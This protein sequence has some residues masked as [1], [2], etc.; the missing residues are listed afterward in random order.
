MK[1]LI[2]TPCEKVIQDVQSGNSLI[3]VF[4][5][6]KIKLPPVDAGLPSDAVA[7]KDWAIFSKWGLLPEEEGR[8]YTSF[9]EVFWPDGRLLASQR[10]EAAQPTKHG[11][12]FIT[13]LRGFPVG[14]NGNIKV[15]CSLES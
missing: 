11:M 14:Q 5:G 12:A 2:L 13:N 15:L 6:I 3:S 10:L 9:V 8:N 4:H 1:L 7:P